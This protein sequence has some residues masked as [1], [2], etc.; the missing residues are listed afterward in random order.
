M[1]TRTVELKDEYGR[2]LKSATAMVPSADD[3]AAVKAG[4]QAPSCFGR[5]GLV[6]A[7]SYRGT[8]DKDGAPFV[9][10]F[11]AL[12]PQDSVENGCGCSNSMVAGELMR[13]VGLT[14]ILTSA[15]CDA[16]EAEMRRE[17][18]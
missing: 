7:V 15:E 16:L 6:T 8:R 17:A 12:G 3:V 13:T 18:K 5:L 10:Y 1:T 9:G 11:V 2:V 14:A 4:G